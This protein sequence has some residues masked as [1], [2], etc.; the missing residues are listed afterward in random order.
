MKA[1]A[2][3][4]LEKAVTGMSPRQHV[5]DLIER[6]RGAGSIIE[7]TT[8]NAL[9]V[10][11]HETLFGR[12][13]A[14]IKAS[15]KGKP[16]A[17]VSSATQRAC[18]EAMYLSKLFQGCNLDVVRSER[19]WLLAR[20]VI[21][22]GLGALVNDNAHFDHIVDFTWRQWFKLEQ[23]RLAVEDIRAQEF[24][25]V[26]PLLPEERSI[27]MRQHESVKQMVQMLQKASAT[28][29]L[30]DVAAAAAGEARQY[31]LL[32][33]ADVHRAFDEDLAGLSCIRRVLGLD[34]AA[35]NPVDTGRAEVS[36]ERPKAGR[37]AAERRTKDT[38]AR[39]DHLNRR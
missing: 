1:A 32:A 28:V 16:E 37:R 15:M 12:I 19:E 21:H 34:T 5:F 10:L 26:D 29:E 6:A 11:P 20:L 30:P 17:A 14:S 35:S 22:Y 25:G 36:E 9:P 2:A 31:R 38:S 13:E 4:R 39:R 33:R 8:Q 7:W 18:R 24:S 23:F 3:K 27:L